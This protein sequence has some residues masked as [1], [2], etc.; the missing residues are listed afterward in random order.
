LNQKFRTAKKT[1]APKNF[2][3]TLRFSLSERKSLVQ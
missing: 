1:A 3:V 2:E